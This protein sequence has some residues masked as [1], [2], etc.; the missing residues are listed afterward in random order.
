M[1]LYYDKELSVPEYN[2]VVVKLE[3]VKQ[4]RKGFSKRNPFVLSFR[5]SISDTLIH[6]FKTG[7]GILKVL[8]VGIVAVGAFIMNCI[9]AII[10]AITE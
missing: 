2:G 4:K 6:F 7:K 1:V 8:F 9:G 5:K 10:C 3:K